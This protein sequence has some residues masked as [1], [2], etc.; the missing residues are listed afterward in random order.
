LNGPAWVGAENYSMVI[1]LYELTMAASYVQAGM[2]QPATFELFVRDLPTQ[3]SFLVAAGVDDAV[4]A[5]TSFQVTQ[6]AL[7]YLTGLEMF[8]SSFL[9]Y[10]A[11]LSFTGRVQAVREGEIVF[12]N[13]PILEVTAPLPEA[14]LVE[15]LLINIVQY[16]TM[17][18]SKAARIAIACGEREFVDFAA[19]RA[20]GVDAA[21][22]GARAAFVGGAVATSLTLAGQLYGIPVTGTMA[23]SYVTTFESE[24]EAFRAFA[25]R[26]PA[27][28][29]LL[30][31]TYDTDQGARVAVQVAD[32]LAVEGIVIRGVRLDSGDLERLARSVRSILDAGGH[33]EIEI[34]AS[35]D[36]DEYRIAEML[37]NDAPV[38]AFGVGTRLGTSADAPYLSAVYKLVARG[39]VPK[40]KHSAEKANLPGRKQVHR[41]DH[42][43]LIALVDEEV[44]GGRPLL[45]L[46]MEDGHRVRAAELL[47]AAQER[48]RHAVEGLPQRLRVLRSGEA[49][50]EVDISD[51]IRDLIDQ[52][53]DAE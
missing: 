35:G 38:N 40:M 8:D 21:L 41:F 7:D 16:Q 2:E 43:D 36:L 23:H 20:H 45:E 39:G 52:L 12:P 3:R 11:G 34:F 17:V 22:K 4:D 47:S 25:R 6:P 10:L 49:P 46:V 19:R 32:E 42:R 37:A 13:E 44:A 5:L 24:R 15:T 31:D 1:D 51:G 28:A 26:F 48:R 18:A 14:Q 29:V 30:I 9:D 33:P 27:N 50:Y 53:T